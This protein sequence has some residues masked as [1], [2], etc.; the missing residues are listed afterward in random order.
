MRVYTTLDQDVNRLAQR[1]AANQVAQLRAKNVSNAAVVVTKPASGEIIAMIGSI[2]YNNEAIDG[3]VNVT[4]AFRQPGSTMK[5]FTY[6][7]ALE[8]GMS[9]IDVLWDT[10]TEIA[11]PGLPVYT[12]RNFDNA[13]HGPMTMRA[14]LANSYNIPAVQTL[15]LV[16]VD[17]LLR[18]LRRLGV[19]TLDEDASN[20]GLSLTLGGGEV[21]LIELTNAFAV[22]ANQ[23]IM[24]RSHL[25]SASS[26][27]MIRFCISTMTVVP[28][29]RST[30]EPY[31]G[32]RR[33]RACSIRASPLSSAICWAT[34]RRAR[35]Q[36][37]PT[38]RCERRASP[39]R[40]RPAPPMM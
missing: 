35:R 22:F 15:R 39:P 14:A 2:D 13:F 37:A 28:K 32:A 7:A 9:T 40:L 27:A 31:S 26:T 23:G 5:P 36:W 29:G 24:F 3:S 10:R 17:Y 6:A 30:S 11:L 19:T 21:S 8:R 16:G 34:I 1:A 38:V 33:P 18:L 12:P 4:T 20:Y 25:S